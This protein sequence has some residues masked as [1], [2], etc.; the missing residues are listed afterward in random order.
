MKLDD[1]EILAVLGTGS[2]STVYKAIHKATSTIYALK[3]L[4]K[5]QL[6]RLNKISSA[7]LE[8][9]LLTRLSHRNIV[10][11]YATFQNEMFLCKNRLLIE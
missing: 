8:K 2:Y 9:Q 7:F 4:S 11:L 10:N 6:L 1:F 3:E 5:K